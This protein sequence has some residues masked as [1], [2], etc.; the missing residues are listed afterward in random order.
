MKVTCLRN[1]RGLSS[2]SRAIFAIAMVVVLVVDARRRVPY[3]VGN[4]DD[5]RAGATETQGP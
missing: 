4:D 3:E 1:L 5:S 2:V